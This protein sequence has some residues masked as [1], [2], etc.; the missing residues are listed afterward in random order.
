ME[1]QKV[2]VYL[3]DY[4]EGRNALFVLETIRHLIENMEYDADRVRSIKILL[5]AIKAK[6]ESYVRNMP[7]DPMSLQVSEL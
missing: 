6:E 1:H 3:E 5:Q 4:T 2:K 7:P